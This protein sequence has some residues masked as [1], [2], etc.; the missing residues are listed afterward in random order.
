[1]PLLTVVLQQLVVL[2]A[3]AMQHSKLP[4]SSSSSSS[5]GT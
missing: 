5:S 2:V 3:P 1:V 4:G